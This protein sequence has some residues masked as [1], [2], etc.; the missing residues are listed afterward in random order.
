M[1]VCVTELNTRQQIDYLVE[2][3]KSKGS[4]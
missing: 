3:L 1:L 2:S 4:V